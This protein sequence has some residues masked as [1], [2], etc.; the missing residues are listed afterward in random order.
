VILRIK[1]SFL[2]SIWPIGVPVCGN[3]MT[4]YNE[5]LPE[6]HNHGAERLGISVDSHW[7]HAAFAKDRH[8]HFPLLSDFEPKGAVAKQ[9]RAFA[10]AKGFANGLY[11]SSTSKGRSSGAIS[12]PLPS[13]QA[14]TGFLKHLKD[15]WD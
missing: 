12:R 14:P 10:K 2:P 6:F 8:L 4:V 13:I 1:W 11:S 7:C 15:E 3:Q 5:I 9:Y